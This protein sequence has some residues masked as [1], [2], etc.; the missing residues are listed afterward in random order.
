[1]EGSSPVAIDGP[2]GPVSS[3][4][5]D[6]P[7]VLPVVGVASPTPITRSARLRQF[8]RPSLYYL[9]SRIVV[10]FAALAA[11]WM[12]P[13]LNPFKALTT[14]W[15]GYWYNLIAQH[16]YPSQ[17]FNENH[18]SRWAFFPA[19]PAV[20]RATVDVTGLSYG[21]ATFL[22]TLILGLTATLAI[23]LA[24]RQVFGTVVADRSVLLFVFFPATYVLSMAYT[25]GLFL[26]AAAG[27]LYALSK[28]YWV[29]A[30]LFAVLAS[31]TRSFGVV[32][33]VCVVVTAVP[34]ILKERKIRPLVAIAI[35]PVGFL[36]WLAYSWAIVGNPLAFVSAEKIWSDSHFVWFLTPL[37][38][39]ERL[40]T[41]VHSWANGQFVL[42]AL[43]VVFAYGGFFLLAKAKDRGVS[44]PFYWWVFT[45]GSIMGMMSASEPASVLRYSLGI[46]PLFAAYAWRMKAAWE[47]PVVGVLAMSQ[48]VLAVIVIV[49]TL[50]PHT[51][52]IWP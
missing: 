2:A 47:G 34:I 39:C 15:D 9:L 42:T 4:L 41:N 24:V 26:T 16:G 18:G 12:V 8:A 44:V 25:E 1:M 17:I 40:L 27:C 50:H 43:A 28:K 19:Y 29:T 45:I 21:G 30:S 49:G 52:T 22:L 33:I 37:I 35:A 51:A 7:V 5:A 46:I 20:I 13:R 10:L 11:K 32:L 36:G 3:A 31:L 23:W 6:A 14:G 38:A 48:G